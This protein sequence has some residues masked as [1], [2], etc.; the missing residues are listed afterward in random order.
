MTAMQ[1]FTKRMVELLPNQYHSKACQV[2]SYLR[3]EGAPRGT[4][5][6]M[7]D[8]ATVH[9]NMLGDLLTLYDKFDEDKDDKM[10]ILPWTMLTAV[11]SKSGPRWLSTLRKSTPSLGVTLVRFTRSLTSLT[12]TTTINSVSMKSLKCS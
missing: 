1:P 6:A 2:D 4:I 11:P 5:Y 10:Y 7:G 8:A 12:R 9:L 3:V